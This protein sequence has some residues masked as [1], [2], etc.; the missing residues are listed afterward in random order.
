MCVEA[1]DRIISTTDREAHGLNW[2]VDMTEVQTEAQNHS[3]DTEASLQKPL[4][5]VN[6]I[7]NYGKP[8]LKSFFYYQQGPFL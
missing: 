6:G 4:Q 7:R 1:Q 5:L 2:T 8:D 3:T